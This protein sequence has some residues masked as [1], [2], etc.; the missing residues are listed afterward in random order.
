M[1]SASSA[2]VSIMA[3]ASGDEP[4]DDDD[5]APTQPPKSRLSSS[6][7][8]TIFSVLTDV[9]NRSADDDLDSDD[10]N[11]TDPYDVSVERLSRTRTE[12]FVKAPEKITEDLKLEA[13]EN[14][15]LDEFLI[16]LKKG[17]F[18]KKHGRHGGRPHDRL[19]WLSDD[20]S[21]I[22]WDSAKSQLRRSI[23]STASASRR[24][25]PANMRSGA[26]LAGIA[27]ADVIEVRRGGHFGGARAVQNNEVRSISLITAQRSVDLELA[28]PET[29]E[30]CADGFALLINK[31]KGRRRH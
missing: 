3:C 16:M 24:S 25:A 1:G 15:F 9:M 31:R 11:A 7:Q 28:D 8:G 22:L 20:E 13:C 17:F 2:L 30:L 12:D 29:R 27:V 10:E 21:Q 5:D 19:V 23:S 4:D 18:V 6:G 26:A 14:M